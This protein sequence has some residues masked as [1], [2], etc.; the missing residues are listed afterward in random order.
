[1]CPVIADLSDSQGLAPKPL[2]WSLALGTDVG[3]IG[4]LI[5]ASAN[6]VR[7]AIVEKEGYE[8]G[9]GRYLWSGCATICSS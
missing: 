5:G 8:I 4:T 2:A 7:T 6:L 3:G 1:M 9:W